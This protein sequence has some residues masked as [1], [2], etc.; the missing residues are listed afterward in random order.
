MDLL[1]MCNKVLSNRCAYT[2]VADDVAK[3]RL[4][5]VVHN[6]EYV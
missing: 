1:Y 2:W 6:Q 5:S 4:Q 3:V